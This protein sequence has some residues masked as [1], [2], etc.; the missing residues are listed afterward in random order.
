MLQNI[1]CLK[2]I[3]LVLGD[4]FEGGTTVVK[5]ISSVPKINVF[6]HSYNKY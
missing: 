1:N 6:S 3:D 4:N 5:I 2:S